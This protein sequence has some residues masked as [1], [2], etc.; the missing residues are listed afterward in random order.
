M[1]GKCAI[2]LGGVGDGFRVPVPRVQHRWRRETG[3][4]G[5]RFWSAG[6]SF[7]VLRQRRRGLGVGVGGHS[8]RAPIPVIAR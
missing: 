2:P 8:V 1:G 7:L 4:A 3:I 5:L 6:L